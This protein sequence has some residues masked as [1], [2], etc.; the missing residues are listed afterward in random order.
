MYDEE[1]AARAVVALASSY[2]RDN[3]AGVFELVFQAVLRE[4]TRDAAAGT[5]AAHTPFSAINEFSPRTSL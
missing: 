3:A 5:A 4:F 2:S 1:P